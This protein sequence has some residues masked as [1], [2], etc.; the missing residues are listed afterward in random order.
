M[1][2][3]ARSL[4][5]LETGGFDGASAGFGEHF[6]EPKPIERKFSFSLSDLPDSQIRVAGPASHYGIDGGRESLDMQK[7][8]PLDG[9]RRH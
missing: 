3:S 5:G 6:D 7:W 4:L 9:I 2:R 8:N 1:P